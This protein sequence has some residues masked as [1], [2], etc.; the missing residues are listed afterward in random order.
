MIKRLLKIFYR[1]SVF[2]LYGKEIG[3]VSKFR[4]KL[5]KRNRTMSISFKGKKLMLSDAAGFVRNYEEIFLSN[6]YDFHSDKANPLI[7]DCG[8]NIGLSVLYFKWKYPN[9][10]IMAF[11]PDPKLFKLLEANISSFEARD[12]E[13]VNAAIWTKEMKLGFEGDHNFSGRI[14]DTGNANLEVD[15]VELKPYLKNDIDFLKIDIEGAETAVLNACKADL[16]KVKKLFF[17]YHSFPGEG[18]S[19]GELLTIVKNA[20]FRYSIKEEFVAQNP[21]TKRQNELVMDLQLSVFCYR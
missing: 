8:S 12:V 4:L 20:G 2:F 3:I 17:E 7:L 14:K 11:E 16:G 13:L 19:L 6:V 10:R 21:Y 1:N 18:Q 5:A 15:A 9:A